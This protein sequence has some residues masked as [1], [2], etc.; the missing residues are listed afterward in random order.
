MTI[1]DLSTVW[2]SSDV[3]ESAIRF[4]QPGE[5]IDVH[6]TAYPGETFHGRVTRIADTVDPQTRTIKVRAEMDNS[7]GR[8]RPE[9][10]GTI[11]HTD[12]MQHAAGGSGGG[13]GAGR[14]QDQSCGW[15]QAPG[16]FRPV[17]VK[18]GERAG[19]MLP[20]L[21]RPDG[22]RPRGGGRRD[23]A[24]RRNRKLMIA[25]LLRFALHQR[26]VMIALSLGLIG[27]GVYSFQ[28]LKVE[29]Y[30]DI[31]DTQAVVITLYPGHAAEEVEQQVTV[32]IERALNSVP[33][34]IARRSRTIFGLSVV[35]LTFAYGTDDYFARAG[36]AGETARRRTARRRDPDARTAGHADR[37]TLPL[38]GGRQGLQRHR[39]ART[40]RTG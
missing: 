3:P 16:R 32:P 5:R 6:L 19:D 38:R 14:R 4:I 26:F 29:A 36:G 7:H 1:A 23:A 35:E 37:R 28:Q 33:N 10:F 34:V 40:A 24:A 39:T 15:R 30:P 22:R 31:S 27:L 13:G 8:L 20:V 25:K 17:E 9:M 21:A 2:V 12:S 18:T 11:R